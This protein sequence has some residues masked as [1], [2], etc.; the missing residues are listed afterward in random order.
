[1]KDIKFTPAPW[2][3][4]HFARDDHPCDC[5]DITGENML[6]SIC[7]INWSPNYKL[8]NGCN[9]DLETAKANARLIS[10]APELYKIAYLIA[11]YIDK[12]FE[13]ILPKTFPKLLNDTLAK[14]RGNN[15]GKRN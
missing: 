1:M 8:E 5:T 4:P 15:N 12:D 2:Y 9:P 14:V 10:A 6:G 7:T 13:E 3:L 11:V